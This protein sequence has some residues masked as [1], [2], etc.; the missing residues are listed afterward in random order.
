MS[1]GAHAGARSGAA[2][3]RQ[4]GFA[5]Y[6]YDRCGPPADQKPRV[7]LPPESKA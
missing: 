7:T 2:R 3:P 1:D 6:R 5:V 4:D